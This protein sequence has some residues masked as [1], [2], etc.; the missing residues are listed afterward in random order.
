MTPNMCTCMD[1]CEWNLQKYHIYY[2]ALTIIVNAKM[3]IIAILQN[4]IKMTKGDGPWTN[5]HP[6]QWH[7][8]PKGNIFQTQSA[9]VGSSKW[10]FLMLDERVTLRK[11][12]KLESTSISVVFTNH[13]MPISIYHM[14]AGA[15][16]SLPHFALASYDVYLFILL[17]RG[18]HFLITSVI[19]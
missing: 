15:F 12:K 6:K 17:F 10:T 2:D 16:P 11:D 8:G 18:L 14:G 13:S 5:M 1:L 9:W 4:E 19:Q 3:G 7:I